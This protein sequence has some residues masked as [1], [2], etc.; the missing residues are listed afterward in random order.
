MK[1]LTRKGRIRIH[2]T[3]FPRPRARAIAFN[4]LFSSAGRFFRIWTYGHAP[5]YNYL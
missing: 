2:L 3:S 1:M 4:G 5:K